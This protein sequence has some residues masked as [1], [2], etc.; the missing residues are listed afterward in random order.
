[1]H[2]IGVGFGRT[3]TLSLK[4][5]LEELGLGPC[6]HMRE[7]IASPDHKRLWL[8][9]AQGGPVD[10][11]RLLGG[12]RSTVDWPGCYFW[13]ELVEAYPEARVVLTV[14]DPERWYSSTRETIY[15]LS[16]WVARVAAPFFPTARGM[17]AMTDAIIW[18]GTFGGRFTD[19][20]HAI[21][22][23]ERHIREVRAHVPADRLLVYDVREG[24]EPLCRFLGVEA[25]RDRPFPHVNDRDHQK[26]KIRRARVLVG[27]LGASLALATLAGMALRRRRR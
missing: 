26:S 14:R 23:F 24:W 15:R 18:N 22:V 13:R 6:Y 4:V 2:V 21:G 11:D 20:E 5:A 16:T 19:R 7:A 12:Y 8:E 1:M 9:A 10:W 3:G 27:S 17:A 25:P